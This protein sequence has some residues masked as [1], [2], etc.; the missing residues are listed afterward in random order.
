MKEY[1]VYSECGHEPVQLWHVDGA[2]DVAIGDYG[3]CWCD[4]ERERRVVKV[5]VDEHYTFTDQ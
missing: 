1:L 4:P 3:L 5:V 2:R